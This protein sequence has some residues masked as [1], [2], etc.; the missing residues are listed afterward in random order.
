MRVASAIFPAQRG[1]V[2]DVPVAAAEADHDGGQ[3]GI[4][5]GDLVGDALAVGHACGPG[6]GLEGVTVVAPEAVERG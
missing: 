3:A 4:G 2:L 6:R 1:W 5:G